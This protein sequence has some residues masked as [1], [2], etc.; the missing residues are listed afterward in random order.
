[1]SK[2]KLEY[3][4][5]NLF[6]V[7]SRIYSSHTTMDR[8]KEEVAQLQARCNELWHQSVATQC[9]RDAGYLSRVGMDAHRRKPS[10]VLLPE[11]VA[12]W[13]L[14]NTTLIEKGGAEFVCSTGDRLP[15]HLNSSDSTACPGDTQTATT[16][17]HV[18]VEE[19]ENKW[20]EDTTF[21]EKEG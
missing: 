6:A 3:Y 12:E 5:Q 4:R 20:R 17:E 10:V 14:M 21:P 9:T 8:S 2:D 1:M 15:V 11:A 18:L 16:S 19:P 7:E 13:V